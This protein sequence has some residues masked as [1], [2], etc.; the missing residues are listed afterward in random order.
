MGQAAYG[1][2]RGDPGQ[3]PERPVVG[4]VDRAVGVLAAGGK[5][6]ACRK[7]KRTERAL[8]RLLA[9]SGLRLLS[10]TQRAKYETQPFPT[11][12]LT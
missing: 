4:N 6:C 7:Q 3:A 9:Q 2:T 12:T 10:A 1:G 8:A 11:L 5:L